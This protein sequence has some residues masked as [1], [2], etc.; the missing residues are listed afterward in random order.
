[1]NF[2]TMV[3][4]LTPMDIANASLLDEATA[5]AEAMVMAYA[6]S[7]LKKKTFFVEKGVFPQTISVLQT[8]AKGF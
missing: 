4:S 6:N 7:N 8:R 1:M 3:I 5:A 2:Q